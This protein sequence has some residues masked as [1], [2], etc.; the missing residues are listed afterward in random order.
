M[1]MQNNYLVLENI[2]HKLGNKILYE[3]SSITIGS[4]INVI[5]GRNGIGKS[6]LFK[7]IYGL[8]KLDKG[9]IKYNYKKISKKDINYIPQEVLLFPNLSARDNILLLSKKKD[10]V[11][12]FLS[13]NVRYSLKK[14][15]KDLSGGEKQMLNLAIGLF[16]EAEIYLI[17]EPF[18]N[19]EKN[20]VA[21]IKGKIEN[22]K[23]IVI[24]IDHQD[25]FL[26]KEIKI[27]QR[28]FIYEE[29]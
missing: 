9:H 1:K 25:L 6:T 12:K 8:E 23:G 11:I 7:L 14:K 4:G 28:S 26:G 16:N 3:N 21:L 20:Y 19:L 24:L 22:L 27:Y 2:S 15:V 17:D 18:N 29:N 13:D 5:K 10:D